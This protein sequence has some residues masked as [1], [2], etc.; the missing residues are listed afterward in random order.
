AQTDGCGLFKDCSRRDDML[1]PSHASTYM[2]LSD[3]FKTDKELAVQIGVNG[4][5]K[6]EHVVSFMGFRF[7]VNIPNNHTLFCT[8]DFAI[9]HVRGW[10]GFDV[11]GAHVVGEN[12]G[13]NVPLQLGFSNGIDFVVRPEGCVVTDTGSAIVPVKARAPPGE[14]FAHLVP[15]LRKGQPWSVVRKRIVQMCCDHFINLS[16]IVVFVLWSGGLEL[17]TMRY[18][19]KVGPIKHCECGKLATCYNSVSHSF[20]CFTHAFGCDYLYNPYCIDIQQ[21][22]YTGSLSSNHHQHCNLHRN[23]HVASGDA[24]MTRCLAIYDCFVKN[25]DWSVTYPFIANENLINKSGRMVQSH[26]MRAALALYKP[27]AIHDIGNPKGIRCAVTDVSWYCYDKQPLNNNV[28]TLEYD[29]ITHGQFDGLCLFWN[30]NVDMYPEFSIVCRFDTR[31]RSLLNLE[32]C[33][34]GS[35]Y[36]NN[37][38]FHTPAFDKRAFAKLK[39]MPFFYYDTSDCDKLHDSINYVPLK[40]S[41]CITRCNVGGAVCSRHADQYHSYVAAYNNFTQAGFTI[42]VPQNF[43]LYNLWQTLAKPNLQ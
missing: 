11:E 25:V 20:Y 19:V 31:Q 23:E 40:A 12:V 17:T 42:W 34:G 8:R 32:G 26:V 39:A 38:A 10:L 30:C 43:D 4:P 3:N 6:Y 14:Q 5:I 16:D 22:G 7:D 1:P 9:R 27:K 13:T 35:L 2:A 24:I 21:W 36:V 41:N 28:K 37:H 15:L 18:F 33:N 29:Y